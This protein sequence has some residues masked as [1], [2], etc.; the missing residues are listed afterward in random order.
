[1]SVRGRAGRCAHHYGDGVPV[2][3]QAQGGV[4]AD[5]ASPALGGDKG[6]GVTSSVVLVHSQLSRA[7]A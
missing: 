7:E 6:G 2:S 3:E 5:E 1:M 4:G